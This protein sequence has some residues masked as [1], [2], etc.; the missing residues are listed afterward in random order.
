[1]IDDLLALTVAHRA[2]QPADPTARVW[3]TEGDSPLLQQIENELEMLELLDRN[4][5]EF[6]DAVIEISIFFQIQ[7]CRGRFTFEMSVVDE[8]YRQVGQHSR[9][10][11]T[12]NFL[13]K[14]QH[15]GIPLPTIKRTIVS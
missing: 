2:H 1:M 5:V 15:G 4:C 12:G 9:Q 14:Q 6:F 10:P 3:L 8:H 13:T 11:V 7:C